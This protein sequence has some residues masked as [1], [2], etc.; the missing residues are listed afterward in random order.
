MTIKTTMQRLAAGAGAIALAMAGAVA[1]G[2]AASAEQGA[3]GTPPG[4][5]ADGTTGTLVVHKYAGSGTDQD[6]DGTELTVTRP[7]LAGVTFD[8]C[9]VD[10]LSADGAWEGIADLAVEDA[11]CDGDVSSLTTGDDGIVSFAGLEIGLYKVVESAFPDGVTP[12]L[13]FLVSIPYP[14]AG[15]DDTW[16]WTVHAYPKNAIEG[17]GEKTVEDPSANGLGSTIP[18]TITTRPI[19]S[20]NDGAPVDSYGV[21]DSLD[22]RLTYVA[23]SATVSVVSA[24]GDETVLTAGDEYELTAPAGAGGDLIVDFDADYVNSLPAGTSFKIEFETTVTAVGDGTIEN[25]STEYVNDEDEDFTTPS[26][27]TEWGQAKLLKYE[28]GKPTKTL[29]GAEFQVYDVNENGTCTAPL[30]GSALTVDGETTF[31]SDAD[32]VVDIPGLYVGKNAED[33]D[34]DYCVVETKAPA[35]YELVSTPILIN[36]KIG[37][38]AEDSWTVTVPNPPVPGPDLP[39]TGA[40]GTL[41][42]TIGGLLLV[43]VGAGAIVVSRRRRNA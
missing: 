31:I 5:A 1:M 28:T 24:S 8:L 14:S 4:E 38:V 37:E 17:D 18:W 32:G 41:I 23:G 33:T 35:G 43:G 2:T 10:D 21:K 42:M 13:D 19:G 22:S 40:Q 3:D 30:E 16:L 27:T 36:V 25:E 6:P 26:V 9:L 12:G 20:F 7:P 15:S 29:D 39:L 34:R 11:E